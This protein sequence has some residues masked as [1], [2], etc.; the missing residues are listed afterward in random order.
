ME[1]YQEETSRVRRILAKP[2]Q[3]DSCWRQTRMIR[4]QEWGDEGFHQIWTVIIY[5]GWWIFTKSVKQDSCKN[6]TKWA[7]KRAEGQSLVTKGLKGACPEFGDW[8]VPLSFVDRNMSL[9][10]KYKRVVR[11]IWDLWIWILNETKFWMHIWFS[12][13]P[14]NEIQ[15]LDLR[16]YQL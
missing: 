5:Q 10:D 8:K 16:R 14:N 4:Y 2:T 11:H 3:Q 13:L 9:V 15:L 1:N 12:P 6:W 7:K